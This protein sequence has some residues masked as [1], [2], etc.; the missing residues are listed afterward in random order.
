MCKKDTN[1]CAAHVTSHDWLFFT[2]KG[3]F[4]LIM[5]SHHSNNNFKATATSA[6]LFKKMDTKSTSVDIKSQD[7]RIKSTTLTAIRM[8]SDTRSFLLK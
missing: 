2:N 5:G 3:T 1:T 6:L 7:V 8:H 4:H